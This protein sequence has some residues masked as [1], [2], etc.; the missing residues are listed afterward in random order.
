MSI[1]AVTQNDDGDGACYA[2][3]DA[4]H[5]KKPHWMI[6]P[7]HCWPL[8]HEPRAL[9]GWLHAQRREEPVLQQV[10]EHSRY[11]SRYIPQ[12]LE[13][14]RMDIESQESKKVVRDS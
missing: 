13:I 10:R 14:P 2:G 1:A 9:A 7:G 11:V 3:G 8:K 4:D 6:V 5:A 12:G